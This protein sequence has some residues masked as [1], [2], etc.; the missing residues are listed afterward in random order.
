MNIQSHMGNLK[1]K[2]KTANT[3]PPLCKPEHLFLIFNGLFKELERSKI[4]GADET[5]KL[6]LMFEKWK[7]LLFKEILPPIDSP[8]LSD[9]LPTN[10][11]NL[12]SSNN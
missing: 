7:I 5:G 11:S 10:C 8:T 4:V 1:K 2:K 6:R 3:V 9:L 12:Y